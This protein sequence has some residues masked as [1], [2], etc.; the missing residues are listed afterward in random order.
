MNWDDF[1]NRDDL[2]GAVV[3]TSVGDDVLAGPITS[4]RR[5]G[6]HAV[7]EVD[8]VERQTG[9]EGPWIT[10]EETPEIHLNTWLPQPIEDEEAGLIVIPGMTPLDFTTI[11]LPREGR[12]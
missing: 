2:V 1:F 9:G 11:T 7:I 8:W 12:A 6:D 10:L 3:D 5:E 4:V